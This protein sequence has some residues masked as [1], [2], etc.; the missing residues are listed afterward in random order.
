MPK[1]KGKS[2]SATKHRAGV[3]SNSQANAEENLDEALAQ[4][5]AVGKIS[6]T[7]NDQGKTI[8]K[9]ANADQ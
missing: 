6:A 5:L 4:L 2:L 9:I 3:T 1:N 8:Y 7:T